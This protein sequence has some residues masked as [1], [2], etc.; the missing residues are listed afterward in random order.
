MGWELWALAG[1]GVGGW[2]WLN[3]LRAREHAI[4]AGRHACITQGMQFLD[5]TVALS[6]TRLKRNSL[7]QLQFQRFYQFEFSSTGDNRRIGNIH[8]LGQQVEA[9]EMDG[10]WLTGKAKVISIDD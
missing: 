10:D 4:A 8:V 1:L 3:G 5:E 9:V 2:Y 7:G 6:K